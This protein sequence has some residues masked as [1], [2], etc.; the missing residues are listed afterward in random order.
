MLKL[1]ESFHTIQDINMNYDC[2]NL[3]SGSAI[4]IAAVSCHNIELVSV[5]FYAVII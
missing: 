1:Q 2:F 5:I 4:Q 3:D